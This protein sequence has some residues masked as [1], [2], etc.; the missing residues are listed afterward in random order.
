MIGVPIPIADAKLD[1]S[2]VK[3]RNIIRLHVVP[4]L[5][6]HLT[7]ASKRSSTVLEFRPCYYDSHLERRRLASTIINNGEEDFR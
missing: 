2:L 7:L 5:V 3:S 1:R 6:A 4:G